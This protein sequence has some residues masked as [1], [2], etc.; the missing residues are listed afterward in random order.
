MQFK[1]LYYMKN[2]LFILAILCLLLE[3]GRM[4]YSG[5]LG[6]MFLIWNLFLAAVP[7]LLST[8]I[9]ATKP[10]GLNLIGK[11]FIWLLFLPNALYI[12]TDLKH[13]H[14][15]PP[16]PEW[17]DCLL[18]FSFS[19]LALLLGLLSFYQMNQ[20]LKRYAPAFVQHIILISISLLAGFG[21][22]LGREQRWNSWD[23]FTNPFDLFS[24]CIS[25]STEPHVWAFSLCYGFAFLSMYHI[26]SSLIHYRHETP[27]QLV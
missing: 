6:Y 10:T 19:T 26:I 9:Q 23:I 25:L 5:T 2:R 7:Y 12:I 14:E 21:V 16:V 20:V 8:H 13:L 27:G 18:L 22:Y 3:A 24:A 17:F 1:V 4:L 15:R 11:C